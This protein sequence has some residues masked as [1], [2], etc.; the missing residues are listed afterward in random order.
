MPTYTRAL[1]GV[2]RLSGSEHHRGTKASGIGGRGLEG[3]D[4]NAS[5]PEGANTTSKS[6]NPQMETEHC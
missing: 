3:A 1:C 5:N 2:S 6:A 4:L